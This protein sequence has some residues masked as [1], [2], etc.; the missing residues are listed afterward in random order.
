MRANYQTTLSGEVPGS[1]NLSV[2]AHNM[3]IMLGLNG[4]A[5]LFTGILKTPGSR[6]GDRITLKVGLPA[7]AGVILDFRT[8]AAGGAHVL[9][10]ETFPDQTFTSDGITTS[11]TFEFVRTA[12]A[13]LYVES[14][15][16]S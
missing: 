6:I 14:S 10:P 16:P 12:S 8:T 1:I 7:I 11:A 9:P 13:W 5:G 15:I 3:S 2:L 4:E